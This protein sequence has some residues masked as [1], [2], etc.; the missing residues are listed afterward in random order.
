MELLA[1]M[2]GQGW[3]P[4]WGDKG[5][6]PWVVTLAYLLAAGL[7]IVAGWVEQRQRRRT[8]QR[9]WPA[10]W[11]VLAAGL[12]LLAVN[13]QLD[14]HTALT[15]VGRDLAR[16]EGWYES[17]RLVQAIF[18][19]LLAGLALV[20]LGLACWWLRGLWRHYG[21]A[22]VGI[23]FLA[24]FI[25]VRAM[26]IHH[27]DWFLTRRLGSFSVNTMLELAGA[28]AIGLSAGRAIWAGS[29]NRTGLP[30]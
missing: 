3:A 4:G 28:L 30:G 29:R 6:W 18:T 5:L 19:G 16:Q 20:G 11:G 14:L 13:K 9:L 10:C 2:T 17:R 15:Y 8:G 22:L 24:L 12:V 27:V 26:S 21:L 7:C 25:I 1:A 23:T